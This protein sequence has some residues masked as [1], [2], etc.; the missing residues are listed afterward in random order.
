MIEVLYNVT[1]STLSPIHIGLG[2]QNKNDTIALTVKDSKEISMIPGTTVKGA[3]RSSFAR[4]QDGEH[5]PHEACEC[6]V[7]RLFGKGG[8][9]PSR[10][11]VDDFKKVDQLGETRAVLS[12]NRIDRHRKVC[13]E[14]ALFSKEVVYGVYQGMITAYVED[15]QQKEQLKAALQLIKSIGSGKS[16]GLGWVGVKV[17]EVPHE[18]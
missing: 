14:G 4:L 10:I 12:S 5:V 8:F 6:K 15:E 16:R 9:S 13:V 1:I 7:C 3:L 2:A 17:E 11:Y 18:G